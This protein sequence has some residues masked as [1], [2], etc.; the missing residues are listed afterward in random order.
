M[1]EGVAVVLVLVLLAGTLWW[2]RSKGL[3]RFAG[4]IGGARPGR[5]LE[6]LERLAL[7]S[8]HSLCLVRVD[9]QAVLVALS[10]SGCNLL[11]SS[12]RNIRAEVIE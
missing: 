5:R 7:S 12:A 10:P 4:P 3:A 2:L 8:Q 6:I 1:Q 11:E 9:Q